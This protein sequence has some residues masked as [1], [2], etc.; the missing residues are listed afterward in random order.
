[1]KS[2]VDL[3]FLLGLCTYRLHILL[4]LLWPGLPVSALLVF[5]L[6]KAMYLGT[7]KEESRKEGKKI[8]VIGMI[9]TM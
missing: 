4:H 6:H 9:S 8:I 3:P 5:G 1:M 2:T 7:C